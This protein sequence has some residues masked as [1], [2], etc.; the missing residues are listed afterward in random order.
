M[1]R[2]FAEMHWYI[3]RKRIFG[4]CRWSER[5]IQISS[6]I[7][8][9]TSFTHI[10]NLFCNFII[11]VQFAHKST[12]KPIM[13]QAQIYNEANATCSKITKQNN[14]LQ[15]LYELQP[16]YWDHTFNK[17]NQNSDYSGTTLTS[18]TRIIYS[19]GL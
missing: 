4:T 7:Y 10:I 17:K 9:F 19:N 15:W 5:H 2:D 16:N 6:L 13:L 18:N 8:L 12:T 14:K 11:Y 1:F 3:D